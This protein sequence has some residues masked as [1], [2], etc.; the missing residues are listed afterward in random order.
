MKRLAP[1]FLGIVTAM[2]ASAQSAHEHGAVD[3]FIAIENKELEVEFHSAANNI[4][5][6]ESLSDDKEELKSINTA[7]A[8]LSII[9]NILAIPSSAECHTE[10]AEVNHTF[11]L[12]DDHHEEHAHHNEHDHD[13]YDHDKHDH[14]K[15]GHENHEHGHDDHEHSDG[16]H[17]DF[18][19]HYHIHCENVSAISSLGLTLMDTYPEIEKVR[20]QLI[21]DNGQSGGTLKK[22]D[23][24]PV[25]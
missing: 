22:G 7:K 24:L 5:G 21:S 17:A 4:V 11:N 12:E 1:L 8:T 10:S 15:H 20:Y 2:Q 23:S 25:K 3:L 9:D 14:D 6:F 13:K 19:A 18:E 16:G